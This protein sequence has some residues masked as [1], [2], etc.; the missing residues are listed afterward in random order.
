MRLS[1]EELL[2]RAEEAI[3]AAMGKDGRAHMRT[4]GNRLTRAVPGFAA[5]DYGFRSITE[6]VGTLPRVELTKQGSE[7]FVRWK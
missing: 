7:T 4:I 5:R 1:K 3:D 6:L 2:E